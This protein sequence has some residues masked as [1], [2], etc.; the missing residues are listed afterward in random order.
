MERLGKMPSVSRL[1]FRHFSIDGVRP[2]LA[3]G[4]DFDSVTVLMTGRDGRWHP[5][6]GARWRVA[7]N[8]VSNVYLWAFDGKDPWAIGAERD[9]G[10]NVSIREVGHNWMLE[11]PRSWS[12]GRAV[13]HGDMNRNVWH[14]VYLMI[15]SPGSTATARVSRAGEYRQSR[16]CAASR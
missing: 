13:D 15:L 2:S 1:D 16:P 8:D 14:D 4:L 9:R 5:A 11:I 3:A 7:V 10:S 12:W 6:V